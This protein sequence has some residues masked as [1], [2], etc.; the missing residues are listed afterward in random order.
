[1]SK[2][3]LQAPKLFV[4]NQ[5]YPPDYAPTGQLIHELVENLS[6][7]GYLIRV[8]TGQPGYAFSKKLALP[9]ERFGNVIIQRTRAT[10]IWSN[11]I[12]GK[13]VSGLLFFLRTIL[14]LL[15]HLKKKDTLLLTTAPPFLPLLGYLLHRITGA[16]YV[17]LVYDLYPDVAENLGVVP[18]NHWTV[19]FWNWMNRRTWNRAKKIIVLSQTMKEE[20]LAKHPHLAHK[21]KIISNWADPNW[22][23]PLEKDKNWFAQEYELTKKFTVLYSGNMGRC[24]DLETILEA[25]RHLQNE[26]FQFVFIGGGAKYESS[27]AKAQEWG[28]ENCLFLPY[29]DREVLPFSLTACDLSLVS[30]AE[31][32]SGVVA[33]SKLYSVLATGRPLA[34]ISDSHCFLREIVEKIQ[35]GISFANGDSQGLAQFIREMAE[36]P[37]LAQAMGQA[38]RNYLTSHCTLDTIADQYVAALGVSVAAQ[39]QKVSFYNPVRVHG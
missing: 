10:C 2:F 3:D 36:K 9:L 34:V 12:R 22:I 19:K 39:A 16:S 31:K 32:M 37:E 14:H 35:C 26:P 1:M 33:P 27:I 4:V 18:S 38:G 28:L 6:N 25:A 20:I 5:F 30:V 24:H 7:R 13:A 8:F 21:I 11:R 29:Q 23:V 17:C 15:K